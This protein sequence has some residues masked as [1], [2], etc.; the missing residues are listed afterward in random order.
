MVLQCFR[1]ICIAGP[2]PIFGY[3]MLSVGFVWFSF[4]FAMFPVDLNRR[5]SPDLRLSDDFL[6]FSIGFPMVLICLQ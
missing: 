3:L 6:W 5:S 4:G 2:R 1:L